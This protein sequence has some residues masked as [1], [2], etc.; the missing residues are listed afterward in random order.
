MWAIEASPGPKV[1]YQGGWHHFTPGY[2]TLVLLREQMIHRHNTILTK[3]QTLYLNS[4]IYY[5][6]IITLNIKRRT[7]TSPIS[8]WQLHRVAP[9]K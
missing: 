7:H 6:V 4:D 3:M 9:K 8:Y 1:A 5:I 2:T